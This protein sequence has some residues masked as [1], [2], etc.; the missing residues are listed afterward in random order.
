MPVSVNNGEKRIL[1][2]DD[3][4]IIADTLA[5]IFEMHGYSSRAVY[6]AEAALELLPEWEPHL[7]I[8][9]IKLPGMSGI[10]LAIR[11]RAE[12]PA[13]KLSLISGFIDP[14]ALLEEARQTGHEFHFMTKPVEPEALLKLAENLPQAFGEN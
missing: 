9:D 11:M 7:A 14:T 13:C 10:D 6:S 4:A 3:E 12:Y 2:V 5:R 1:V 8:L